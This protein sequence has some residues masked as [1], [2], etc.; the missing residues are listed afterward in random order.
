MEIERVFL[1]DRLPDLPPTAEPLRI[2]QGYLPDPEP[3]DA[4][5]AVLEGRLRRV[6]RADGRIECVHTVKRG[7][8]R[9]REETERSIDAADFERDWPLTEGRRLSKTRYRVPDG[10]FVWEIDDFDQLDL[11]I[12]EV[13]LDH[14]DRHVEPPGWLAP[15]VRREV[16]EDPR[17]R[18]FNLARCVAGEL[19]PPG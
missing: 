5:G 2:E 7:L 15:R 9:V 8:G 16:T 13:E 19:V 10:D 17:F 6:T 1:L 3:G 11:V 4:V 18:N 12:A 14:A